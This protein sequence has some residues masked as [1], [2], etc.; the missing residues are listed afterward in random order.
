[1][2]A[3][4]AINTL[5]PYILHFFPETTNYIDYLLDEDVLDRCEN[6]KYDETLNQVIDTQAGSNI[7]DIEVGDELEGFSFGKAAGG[8]SNS[9]S[10]SSTNSAQVKLLQT[11]EKKGI[12]KKIRPDEEDSIS[13]FGGRS[14]VSTLASPP[15][16]RTKKKGSSRGDDFS[17]IS[18]MSSQTM[19]SIKTLQADTEQ[20]FNILQ[21]ENASIRD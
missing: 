2:E 17:A 6:L 9:S 21:Q 15:R 13:T 16:I 1:M 11:G 4:C 19:E 14:K 8:S 18:E 12:N 5:V 7:V 20:K 10:V 3:E